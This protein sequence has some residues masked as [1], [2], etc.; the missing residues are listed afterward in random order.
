VSEIRV[1][2]IKTRAG[3]VP[4]ASDVG[5]NVTGSVIQTVY[6]SL[7]SSESTTSESFVN[8]SLAASITPTSS[9]NKILVMVNA[10]MYSNS[11]SIHAVAGVFRGDVSGTALGNGTYNLGSAY[12]GSS[13][14]KG[15]VC[16]AILD[17]PSTTSATTYTIGMR[18]NGSSGTAYIN[19]NSESSTIVLQEIAG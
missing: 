10:A 7:S 8:T 3:A 9:S 1:D 19:V 12:A 5:I 11:N 17:S 13:A 15:Y 2:A 4:R 18:R 14:V 6:S 16:C